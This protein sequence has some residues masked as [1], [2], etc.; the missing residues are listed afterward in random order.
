MSETE[1]LKKYRVLYCRGLLRYELES[2]SLNL[3]EHYRV[4]ASI[5]ARFYL[6]ELGGLA[7]VW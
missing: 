3:L 6:H 4:K 1:A 2:L 7:G 5:D